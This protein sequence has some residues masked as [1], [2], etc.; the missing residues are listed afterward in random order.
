MVDKTVA[1]TRNRMAPLNRA[2]SQN[3][4]SLF[5]N[6][7][8][9]V[10]YYLC[11]IPP[12]GSDMLGEDERER[13]GIVAAIRHPEIRRRLLRPRAPSCEPGLF[14]RPATGPIAATG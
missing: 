8:K 6:S 7:A 11:R 2:R 10:R 4:N 9:D 12:P 13:S 5:R 3:V 14:R 1:P